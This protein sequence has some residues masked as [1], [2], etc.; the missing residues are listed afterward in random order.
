M[1]FDNYSRYHVCMH[2]DQKKS[3]KDAVKRLIDLAGNQSKLADLVGVD[4]SHVWHWL[5]RGQR[6]PAER[7]FDVIK[8]FKS[9]GIELT[10]ADIR[11]DLEQ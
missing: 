1:T 11:P 2:T 7:V 8:A 4:R 3:C 9:E 10:F 6:I 5:H